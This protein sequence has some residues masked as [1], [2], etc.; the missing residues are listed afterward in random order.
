LGFGA[1]PLL[2]LSQGERSARNA[3]GEGI[4]RYFEV[5][6][7]HPLAPLNARLATF[8]YGRGEIG[9]DA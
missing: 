5:L 1:K 9:E 8:P 4:L 2:H 3:P 6:T 7:P